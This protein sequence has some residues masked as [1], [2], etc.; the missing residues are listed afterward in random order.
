MSETAYRVPTQRDALDKALL[1]ARN[2]ER[3]ASM[4]AGLLDRD[5]APDE[6]TLR[7]LETFVAETRGDCDSLAIIGKALRRV[8]ALR[9]TG[10]LP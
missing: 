10:Q 3:R 5:D 4:I 1:V 6:A 7:C 8:Q 9:R 2:A